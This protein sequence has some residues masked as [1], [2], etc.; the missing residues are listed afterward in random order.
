[1]EFL[2]HEYW[3]GLP[4]SP[5]GDL[6]NPGIELES[7]SSLEERIKDLTEVEVRKA[8]AFEILQTLLLAKGFC[9]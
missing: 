8:L 1:M 9:V 7:E 5:L 6:P 3:S 2:K 4:F